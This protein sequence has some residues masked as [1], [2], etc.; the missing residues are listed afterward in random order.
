[1]G[2]ITTHSGAAF[3]GFGSVNSRLVQQATRRQRVL[4]AVWGLWD[5]LRNRL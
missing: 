5:V 3:S 2:G 1:M 4:S